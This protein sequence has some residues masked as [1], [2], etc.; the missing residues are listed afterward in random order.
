MGLEEGW[1]NVLQQ[2]MSL[3]YFKELE[4]FIEEERRSGCPIY[5]PPSLVFEAFHHTPFHKVK[6]V[7]VGQDPYHGRGQAHG[8]AFSVLPGVKIPPSLKNIIK[9]LTS[10]VHITTPLTGCLTS[11]ADQGVLL[12]N[13]TLTVREGSARS[14]HGMGW[15]RFTDAVIQKLSEREDP[16]VFL[17]WGKL[18]EE[19]VLKVW[20]G[21]HSHHLILVA[22]HPSPYSA[23]GFIGCR[24]FSKTNE[25]LR[26][27]GKSPIDWQ[28]P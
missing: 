11:W 3:P 23:K 21:A 20:H 17:L 6:V 8:L 27:W 16:I 10:D 13:A 14:H 19:K 25:Q 15:E 28:I 12:L 7:I 24:H 1:Q 22:A 2:E 4:A 5:P 9:E 18:A 26:A